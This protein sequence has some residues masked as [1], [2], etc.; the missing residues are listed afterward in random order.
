[1]SSQEENRK[2]SSLYRRLS[3]YMKKAN[4]SRDD[5]MIIAKEMFSD[6]HDAETTSDVSTEALEDLLFGMKV[7]FAVQAARHSNGTLLD[8]AE[9]IL[10]KTKETAKESAFRQEKEDSWD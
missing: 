2:R 6:I 7:W 10:S 8:E 5:F 9:V 1:M 3:W 4:I